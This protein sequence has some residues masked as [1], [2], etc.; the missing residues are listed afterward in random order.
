MVVNIIIFCQQLFFICLINSEQLNANRVRN[1]LKGRKEKQVVWQM[2]KHIHLPYNQIEGK[3]QPRT[4]RSDYRLSHAFDLE[5]TDNDNV[6][7]IAIT[8]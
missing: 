7:L 4:R 1:R 8:C 3:G 5:A 6:L 2:A